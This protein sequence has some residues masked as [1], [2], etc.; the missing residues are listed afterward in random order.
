MAFIS[1][2][3]TLKNGEGDMDEVEFNFGRAFHQL[4]KIE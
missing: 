4:G 1:K 3:R 2:Y